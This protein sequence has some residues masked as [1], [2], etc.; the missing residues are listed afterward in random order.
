M[1][2]PARRLIERLLLGISIIGTN[3]LDRRRAV[4]LRLHSKTS[5]EHL[6]VGEDTLPVRAPHAHHVLYVEQRRYVRPLPV[7]IIIL[8]TQYSLYNVPHTFTFTSDGQI[9]PLVDMSN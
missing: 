3:H 8:T 4:L 6:D 7:I 1:E 5:I 9:Q 2:Q